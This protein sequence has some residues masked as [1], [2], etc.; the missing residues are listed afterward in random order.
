MNKNLMT[1]TLAASALGWGCQ[2]KE[3]EK[4]KVLPHFNEATMDISAKPGENFYQYAN[5]NWMKNNPLPNDKS[6]YGAFDKLAEE[7]KQQVKLVIE[8]AAAAN[9][10]KGTVNQQIGDFFVA[11]MDTVAIEKTGLTPINAYLTQIDAIDSKDKLIAVIGQLQRLQISPLFY[12]FAEADMKN[13]S[14][15]IANLYQGGLGMPDRDYYFDKGE[16]AETLR[17]AYLAYLQSIWTNIG[18]DAATALKN[19][20]SVMK[21]ETQLA[22]AHNTMLENRDPQRTYNKVDFAGLNSNS[23]SLQWSNLFGAMKIETPK[24]FNIYQPKYFVQVSKMI[25]SESLDT[26]KVYLKTHLIREVSPYLPKVFVDARFDF[27]GK[28][29]SGQPQMEPRWK[30]VQNTTSSALGEA[31]GQ[32]FVQEYFPPQA[33]AR[34]E[35]LVENLRI[36]LGERIGQLSWMS[37]STKKQALEKLAAIR[38]KIGYPNKWRDYS[39]LDITR[40]SYLANVL[41]SNEFDFEFIA[42]K[43]GKPVDKEEWGMTPQ[44]VN[45]YY[46]PVNNEIVFPAAILQPPFFYLD[47]DDAVNYGAIGVVIGH[48]ISH[49]FDDQGRQFDKTGNLRDWWTAQDADQFKAKTQILIDQ[50]NRFVIKDSIHANGELTLGENIADLGGLSISYQAF[51]NTLKGKEAPAPIDGFTADQRFYLAYALIWAQNIREAEMLRRVKED[52]HSLGEHRVMGPLVNIE[53]FYQAFG[54]KEGAK[55]FIPVEKRAIIW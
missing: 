42:N 14:M 4:A 39:K 33:K 34:M 29:L 30:R 54:I 27:Y 11:G 7:N 18:S 51:H 25:D 40:D 32:L 5:G 46:N 20:E 47:G 48:E 55:M 2:P 37:D 49:G 8:K 23:P 16:R 28:T 19:S 13:S 26:W 52:V 21:L 53:T 41:K 1:L 15:V 17:K 43:I 3:P 35:Q 31:I 12:F 44:T 6:R 36:A 50:F 10:A 24:E 9:A 45:A 38:V 22:S